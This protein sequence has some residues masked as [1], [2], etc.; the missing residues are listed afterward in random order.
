MI[1][2]GRVVTRESPAPT[3]RCCGSRYSSRNFTQLLVQRPE[4]FEEL[5]D[6]FRRSNVFVVS[7][8]SSPGS[9]KT[10]F[11]KKILTLL[12][13]DYRV[14]ALVGDLATEN[15]A[16][17]LPV[18]ARRQADHYRHAVSSGSRHGAECAADVGYHSVRFSL[19]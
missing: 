18:A 8:V 14:A 3:A 10:T 6:E 5:G 4:L 7:L 12:R 16:Q 11:L 15:D 13:P 1:V 2:Q 9:G 17:R 19:C